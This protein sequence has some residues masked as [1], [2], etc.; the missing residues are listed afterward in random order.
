MTSSATFSIQVPNGND[1]HAG[2]AAERAVP[3]RIQPDQ[4]RVRPTINVV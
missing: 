1:E 3:L 4:I 2:E